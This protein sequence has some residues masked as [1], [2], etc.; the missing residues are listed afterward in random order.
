MVHPPIA[1]VWLKR[2]LRLH[3]HA[4]LQAALRSA[5]PVVFLAMV[6]PEI[7]QQPELSSDQFQFWWDGLQYL[8]QEIQKRQGV[9]WILHGEATTILQTIHEHHP[10]G[11]LFAHEETGTGVTYARDRRV[12]H[13]CRNRSVPFHE[14]WQTGVVRR[15]KSRNGWN[16]QWAQ[17]MD[18]SP[19]PRPEDL[20]AWSGQ[21]GLSRHTLHRE[22]AQSPLCCPPQK[23]L[24]QLNLHPLSQERPPSGEA[25]AL[26][27][28]DDFLQ[29]RGHA[30]SGGISSPLS[31]PTACSRLSPYLSF[32]MVSMRTVWQR[33][34]E[35]R[36]AL[37]FL[38]PAQRGRWPASLRSFQARLHWHCHFMQKLEDE[39]ALEF[40][41]MHRACDGLRNH[42]T[43]DPLRLQAWKYGRTGYPFVDACMRA[44][45]AT[46]WLNFRMRAMVVSF[47]SY[48][49]WLHWRH[50]APYL[51]S[52]FLDFEAGIHY[53]QFQMQSGTTGIN[54]LRMYNPVKQGLEQDPQG[55]FVR[56]WIP[57]LR[58]IPGPL[59]HQ[60]W[61]ASSLD[62][63]S[64]GVTV[65]PS[66]RKEISHDLSRLIDA[67]IYPRPI[68]DHELAVREAR[69]HF[70]QLRRQT[71]ARTEARSIAQRHG[72]RRNSRRTMI[73]DPVRR[74]LDDPSNIQLELPLLSDP[75]NEACQG[76]S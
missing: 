60:P 46:G 50:T 52:L 19:L 76:T 43:P 67:G 71:E 28:L 68:V 16:R 22:L 61:K 49:L 53:S 64:W 40:E 9:L 21:P 55:D 8:S 72:S 30:Y 56:A 63:K 24:D 31:A 73:Q 4:P 17:R 66:N 27:T 35:R 34:E 7:L 39:P 6:E 70:S 41:N 57:E 42:D 33:S 11:A 1:L 3:D 44:L 75:P 62:L 10:I 59:V 5:M 15:L 37:Q 58:G 65:E 18:S 13:W 26:S 23:I 74:Q 45:H 12:R 25:A 51:G 20:F 47:A 29:R 69:G 38:P 32:G 2:D 36:K 14:F 54:T 48:D